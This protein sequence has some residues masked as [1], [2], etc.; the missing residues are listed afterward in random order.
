MK[1]STDIILTTKKYIQ[2]EGMLVPKHTFNYHAGK[3]N[4]DQMQL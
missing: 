1:V 3:Y 2:I 4:N